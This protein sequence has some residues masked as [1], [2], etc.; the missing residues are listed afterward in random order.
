M[1]DRDQAI[2]E[3]FALACEVSGQERD[4]LL[5]SHCEDPLMRSSVESLLRMDESHPPG[6]LRC[7]LPNGAGDSGRIGEL[8]GGRYRLD[9]EIGQGASGVVY[10]ATQVEP[11]ERAVAIKILKAG[12]DTR[13]IIARFEAER[14]TLAMLDHPSIARVLD[15]GATQMGRPYFVMDL[16]EGQSLTVFC[17]EHTLTIE[18][19]LSLMVEVCQAVHHA[20]TKGVIHRDLKPGNILVDGHQ[21]RPVVRVID[22]G[23]A[24]VLR[25]HDPDVT[26][27]TLHGQRLGTPAYMSPEQARGEPDID[28]RADIYALGA[29]LY[30]TLSG[31]RPIDSE[32]ARGLST[33]R[34][35]HLIC[36][37]DPPKPSVRVMRAGREQ[38]VR[39]SSEA[40]AKARSLSVKALEK[41]LRGDLDAIVM[42]AMAKDRSRRYQSVL[43][44]AADL[45]AVLGGMP[46]RARKPS[47]RYRVSRF[48]AR[49]KLAVTAGVMFVTL[50]IGATITTSVLAITATRAQVR[51]GK[52]T[53]EADHQRAT[54]QA[55]QIFMEE[56]LASASELGDNGLN[57]TMRDVLEATTERLN[58]GA[59]AGAPEVEV[60][61]RFSLGKSFFALGRSDQAIEHF[62]WSLEYWKQTRPFGDDL[63]LTAMW[64][65]GE[66][67]KES[68]RLDESMPVFKA[69]YD[70]ALEALGPEDKQVWLALEQIGN[71]L[72]R[73]GNRKEALSYH[74]RAYAG[75]RKLYGQGSPET[76]VP[77]LDYGAVLAS[78]GRL[79]EAEP[80]IL[81]SIAIFENGGS[82][83]LTSLMRAK[84]VLANWIYRKQGRFDEAVQVLR[85][86]LDLAERELGPWHGETTRMSLIL[87]QFLMGQGQFEEAGERIEVRRVYL[88]EVAQVP[89]YE[90]LYTRRET[91]A[92]LIA[93]GKFEQAR[94]LYVG[95]EF[96]AMNILAETDEVAAPA[97]SRRL[98]S[99]IETGARGQA[100]V[101]LRQG[102]I[103]E[104]KA[105]AKVSLEH[106]QMANPNDPLRIPNLDAQRLLLLCQVEAGQGDEAIHELEE[107]FELSSQ[108]HGEKHRLTARIMDALG[109]ALAEQAET[110]RARYLLVTSAAMLE[111]DFG[112][113]LLP[114]WLPSLTRHAKPGTS[115]FA[116]P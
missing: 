86:A 111:S 79:D 78:L 85:G 73:M 39:E 115:F 9:A 56:M 5:D 92:L 75:L 31:S 11:I 18:K 13:Q 74:E 49:N 106:A 59:L 17:D 116:E 52:A 66:T 82:L 84:Q 45:R 81:E 7:P 48:V 98:H 113:N 89:V 43:D 110:D 46:V 97:K 60:Q 40:I 14:Q 71:T 35:E 107:L 105:A 61:V 83:E 16:I 55:V 47:T 80:R 96:D 34:L 26:L 94:M 58:A 21:D 87:G 6:F 41:N 37:F 67:L 22:Y 3:V 103:E 8:L 112:S 2:A 72:F 50:L 42:M 24:K 104:A 108:R 88:Y 76:G 10:R 53:V 68:H 77:A 100:L 51:A 109:H 64:F 99:Y 27:H 69:Y 32:T 38:E 36:A 70:E 25:E 29:V 101:L 102:M 15:A 28:T 114:R 54:A 57:V 62:R 19:R 44:L 1:T 93:Q 91:A 90:T 12:M 20:H 33:A 65:Y 30:E 95:I 23:I 4:A 63:R